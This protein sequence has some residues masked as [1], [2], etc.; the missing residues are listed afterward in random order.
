MP[1]KYPWYNH[2]AG[3]ISN[4]GHFSEDSRSFQ[5]TC[6][7]T[8]P[9]F[10]VGPLL[11]SFWNSKNCCLFLAS[12]YLLALLAAWLSHLYSTKRASRVSNAFSI[13]RVMN[14]FHSTSKTFLKLKKRKKLSHQ[15]CKNFLQLFLSWSKSWYY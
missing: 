15:F 2:L 9:G 10:T 14:Y 12:N 13:T 11:F 3:S 5:N 7:R 4:Q 1:R 6:T 8:Q